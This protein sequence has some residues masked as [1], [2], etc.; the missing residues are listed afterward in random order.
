MFKHNTYNNQHLH[1]IT[2]EHRDF[3]ETYTDRSRMENG[4]AAAVVL[5]DHIS[6]LGL[7]TNEFIIYLLRLFFV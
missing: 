5:Q 3:T 7:I 2:Y 6:M 1:S 4:A